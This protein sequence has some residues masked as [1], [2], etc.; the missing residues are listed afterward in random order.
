MTAEKGSYD[1]DNIYITYTNEKFESSETV[2]V[3][4]SP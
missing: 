2:T 4:V 1:N 3:V